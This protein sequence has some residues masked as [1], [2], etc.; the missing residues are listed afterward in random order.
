MRLH[1][2]ATIILLYHSGLISAQQTDCGKVLEAGIFDQTMIST[3]EASRQT[4]MAWQCSTEFKTHDEAISAGVS[5]GVPVYGVPLKLGGTFS[6]QER[7]AWKKTHCAASAGTS[8]YAKTYLELKHLVAPS[9]IEAWSR[10]VEV[11]NQFRPG[12]KCSVTANDN[13]NVAFAIKY[14]PLDDADTKRP[15]VKS[16]SLSG[17][18]L[19]QSP[20]KQELLP[21]KTVVSSS[22]S[23]PLRRTGKS[24]IMLVVN[25][26]RGACDAYVPG[27]STSFEVAATIRPT[28]E[29][30]T[31]VSQNFHFDNGTGD[32][33]ARNFG[34]EEHYCLSAGEVRDWVGPTIASSNCPTN[35]SY[36]GVPRKDPANPACVF[37][38]W[39]IE[40][41]GKGFFGDCKGRGWLVFD[42][43]VRGDQWSRVDLP[44]F[45]WPRRNYGNQQTFNFKY[46]YG[47]PPGNRNPAWHYSVEL[48]RRHGVNDVAVQLSDS[49][50][51]ALG[52]V[53]SIS[54]E[55]QLVIDVTAMQTPH[56]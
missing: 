25:T 16:S 42:V 32:D 40:G 7:Q 51:S 21:P 1:V 20:A 49:N 45:D 17:A 24:P 30:A 10:C 9:V 47:V 48:R 53:T 29:Q 39:H 44:S 52:V 13:E 15:V 46:P 18:T 22:I 38:P 27:V 8:D 33:C 19:V 41:C 31:P 55:G 56:E 3:S 54:A 5:I 35:A 6:S 37:V 36:P 43:T 2:V 23:V 34:G 50:P 11:V 28:A 12:L 26:T 4:F 14:T